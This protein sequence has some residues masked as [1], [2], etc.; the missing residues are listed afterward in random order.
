[1]KQF[2]EKETAAVRIAAYNDLY[3]FSR[4]M[5]LQRKGYKWMQA[6]HHALICDALMRV[7]SGETKRLIINIPPRYSK[8]E[9]AV[10]NFIAWAMGRVHDSEFIHASYSATLAVN[11]AVNVRNLIQHEEYRAIFPGVVLASQAQGHWKTTAGGVVYATGTGGTITG[12]GAGKHRDGF[13]GCFPANAKVWTEHGLMSIGEIVER[14]IPVKV[15]AYDYKHN[16]ELRPITAW[17]KNP[18][19]AIVRVA[20]SDGATVECTPCHR[21]WTFNRGWVRADSL[22]EDDALPIVNSGIKGSDDVF[23]NSKSFS[24]CA[25]RQAVISAGSVR[26]VIQ[27]LLP[28][29]FCKFGAEI[30]FQS[31]CAGNLCAPGYGFPSVAAPYS[32]NSADSNAIFSSKFGGGRFYAVIN[33]QNLS[34]RQNGKRVNFSLAKSAMCFTVGNIGSSGIV[35]KIFQSVIAGIPVVMANVSTIRSSSYEC[36]QHKTVNSYTLNFRVN[37]QVYS[38]MSARHFGAFKNLSFDKIYPSTTL[39]DNVSIF[40]ADAAEIADRV[41]PFISGYRKPLFVN[42]VRHDDVTYCLTVEKLHNFIINSGFVVKNCIVLDDLHKADEAR[43]DTVRNGVIDWFQNTLESRK[44]S[45]HTPI[46]VI[47][48]RLHEEDIAGWLLNG[49]NG[50]EWE[51]LCLSAITDEGKALWPEKHDIETLR[52]MERAAP[53]VFAGQ[54]M[55]R[56]APL[57]GGLFK[58]DRMTTVE[59]EPAGNIRWVRGWDLGATVGGDPTA[60]VKLGRLDDGRFVIADLVHGDKAP[61]ERDAMLKNTAVSDGVKVKISLPQDPGQAG[62]TQ[63]LHLTRL[64]AGF[65]VVSSPESGDKVTR[66]EPF[67]AQVNAGNVLMVKGAWNKTLLDEMRLFPNGKHDDAIDACSRAFG[68]L[69]AD[70]GRA[71]RVAT[72]LM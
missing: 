16:L 36:E 37:R 29:R 3:W 5:F 43:S 9:L 67:A 61:D 2:D 71:A 42:Y 48:Q 6:P 69:L 24:G 18:A 57:D 23:I 34:I 49:G 54:Y 26:A 72:G 47:M 70:R 53:Y 22:R 13:G 68:E 27:S 28:L 20:F 12:F 59:A 10:V 21:F 63:V 17:H 33:L 58:P 25:G 52:N 45:P 40:A 51:H 31:S 15:W 30:R 44:N 62:K 50:E 8:T 65:N 11:N 64:L 1:M 41:E 39:I 46:I 38:K 55:Q 56:P 4:W 7:F 32:L 60:G 35:S 19:N 14:R 66:A